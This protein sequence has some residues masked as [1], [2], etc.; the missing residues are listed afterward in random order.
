MRDA[1]GALG[2]NLAAG[3]RL[4][5]FMRVDRAAFRITAA[6]LVLVAVVS[7]AIDIDADWL[8]AAHEARFS[9]LGLHGEI[10]ALGLLVLSSAL[11]GA[12]ARDR[13]LYLALPIVILASFPAIQIVHV[14]PDLP[15]AA[16][17]V[18]DFAREIFEYAVIAWMALLAMRAVY[19][20]LDAARAHR[21][22]LAITGAVLVIA[23]IWFAPLLGPLDPW[24]REIDASTANGVSLNPASEPVLAAQDFMMDRALDG[25]EDER[26]GEADLYFV[27]F[28]PDAR[29]AGFVADVDAA[30]RAMDTRWRTNGRSLVLVNSPLTVA[31]RP[32]ATIT[33]L[34]QALLEIGDIIDADEDVVMIYLAGSPGANHTLAAVNPPLDLV[35]LSPQGLRELLDAAGIRWRIIVVSTCEAGTWIDALQDAETAVIASS[36]ANVRGKDCAGGL[37]PTAFGQAFFTEGMQRYD[38]LAR[39]FEVARD[40]LAQLGAPRPVMTMGPAI[41][42][43]LKTLKTK[44]ANRVVAREAVRR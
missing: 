44:Q 42:E 6:Q 10:F 41:A 7:A 11:I 36:S 14:L 27:G 20:C 22:A 35:G 1:I 30:Q 38:D 34:R 31:D 39:A 12:L 24:F 21:R 40:R 13:E 15:V 17:N 9:L 4:A 5:L 26:S 8:R 25:L 43:H 18:S 19:V 23:P 33:H 37:G 29:R 28:A 2:R 3:L 32:F 16:S